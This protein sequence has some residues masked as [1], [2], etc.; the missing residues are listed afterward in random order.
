MRHAAAGLPTPVGSELMR[1]QLS[2]AEEVAQT[3]GGGG[4]GGGGRGGGCGR[5]LQRDNDADADSSTRHGCKGAPIS[6]P[7]CIPILTLWAGDNMQDV[8]RNVDL[9][10]LVVSLRG[11]RWYQEVH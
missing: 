9:P 2:V 4:G 11:K 8:L 10:T 1:I 5:H 6:N 7:V 3:S